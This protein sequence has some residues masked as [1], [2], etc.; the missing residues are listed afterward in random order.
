[1]EASTGMPSAELVT[2]ISSGVVGLGSIAGTIAVARAGR[3]TPRQQRLDEFSVVAERQDRDLERQGATIERLEGKVERLELSLEDQKRQCAE[4][5]QEDR[6]V[7]TA[8]VRI[9]RTTWRHMDALSVPD[10]VLDPGDVSVLE[11]YHLR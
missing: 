9:V 11:Q 7:I 5:R 4:E 10:P 3:R 2:A 1:M 8:F 6:R